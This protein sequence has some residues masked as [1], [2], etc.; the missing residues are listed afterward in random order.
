MLA[1]KQG[2][3]CVLIARLLSIHADTA[4]S[5]TFVGSEN[6]LCASAVPSSLSLIA[7]CL[8]T[9]HRPWDPSLVHAL[10]AQ[11]RHLF[12]CTEARARAQ[13][14]FFCCH[15]E[16]NFALQASHFSSILTD[17]AN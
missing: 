12:C 7:W 14:Q 17:M 8:Q 16:N 6:K 4:P 10:M 3:V 9:M 11:A 5:A 1:F 2:R 15:Y 13:I